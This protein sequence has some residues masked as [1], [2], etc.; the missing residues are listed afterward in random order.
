MNYRAKI[1]IKIPEQK[2][3]YNDVKTVYPHLNGIYDIMP[4]FPSGYRC[5][6]NDK[7]WKV[8]ILKTETYDD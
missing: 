3:K 2:N 5:T 4:E 6:T 1:D 7:Q 8:E